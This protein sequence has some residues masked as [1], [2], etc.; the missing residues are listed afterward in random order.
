MRSVAADLSELIAAAA[1]ALK[2]AGAREVYVFGSAAKGSL[3]ENS[4]VDLAVSG[5]PPEVFFR[6]MGAAHDALN[7]PLDLVD[8]DRD[9]PF[10]RYLKRKGELVRV[11]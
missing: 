5:L 10:T 7:R 8:L 2:A 11:G 3:R 4:D 1:A 9:N 6:A